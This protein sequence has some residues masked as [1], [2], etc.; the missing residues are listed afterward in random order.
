M[1]LRELHLT[2]HSSCAAEW[3]I[4]REPQVLCRLAKGAAKHMGGAGTCLLCLPQ[5]AAFLLV[6]TT[7]EL[8]E[9][10]GHEDGAW[11]YDVESV[12]RQLIYHPYSRV[13]ELRKI[14]IRGLV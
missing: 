8:Q 14:N 6:G 13:L 10:G 4:H 3:L 12:E 9:I 5:G 1:K 2:R 11:C 7:G